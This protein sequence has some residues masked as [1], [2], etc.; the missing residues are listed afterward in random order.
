MKSETQKSFIIIKIEIFWYKMYN[1]FYFYS[2]ILFFFFVSMPFSDSGS[3]FQIFHLLEGQAL[4]CSFKRIVLSVCSCA[5][6]MQVT[7]Q[8]CR[9]WPK[10]LLKISIYC[11]KSYSRNITEIFFNCLL[12]LIGYFCCH[13]IAT[14]HLSSQNLLL[15]PLRWYKQNTSLKKMT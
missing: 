3:S 15:P 2:F 6:R 14:G 11:S 4:I 12:F 13:C 1:L 8:K 9:W 5:W 7:N 10:N